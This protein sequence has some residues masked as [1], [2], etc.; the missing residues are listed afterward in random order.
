MSKRKVQGLVED[1]DKRAIVGTST[2]WKGGDLFG[3]LNRG[4]LWGEDAVGGED[5]LPRGFAMLP[6][7]GMMPPP[8]MHPL[9]HQQQL[10]QQQLSGGFPGMDGDEA[11]GEDGDGDEDGEEDFRGKK[12]SF[13]SGGGGGGGGT[14]SSNRIKGPWSPEEDQLLARLVNEFGAKK[15]SV[16]AEHVSGRIG[17]QCRERWLNHLDASVKKTP[18]SDAEDDTLMAAQNRIGNRWCEIAKLLP[19]RPENAVKNRWNSLM[20]RRRSAQGGSPPM[21]PLPISSPPPVPVSL[22]GGGGG[23]SASPFHQAAAPM[24]SSSSM[25]LAQASKAASS[26]ATSRKRNPSAKPRSHKAGSNQP[27]HMFQ[28]QQQYAQYHPSQQQQQQYFAHQQY[29]QQYQQ[30]QQ[31][32][33][34]D[35]MSPTHHHPQHHHHDGSGGVEP[36]PYSNSN[37]HPPQ[38]FPSGFQSF[39]STGPPPS[40]SAPASGYDSLSHSLLQMSMDEDPLSDLVGLG[41]P[42]LP[43]ST[44]SLSGRGRHSQFSNSGLDSSQLMRA[45]FESTSGDLLLGKLDDLMGDPFAGFLNAVPSPQNHFPTLLSPPNYLPSPSQH[46]QQ[47]HQHFQQPSRAGFFRDDHQL[48]QQ[49]PQQQPPQQ[50]LPSFQEQVLDQQQQD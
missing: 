24:A 42:K 47:Q 41:G 19:G 36:M 48:P 17:K 26:P 6:P 16:I 32:M 33:M 22:S 29:Q 44:T 4:G 12:A 30:Q 13:Q 10:H 20:N 35:L 5:Q 1:N 37:K 31:H 11:E 9:H 2:E 40:G 43:S 21:S 28:Q 14:S 38:G 27:I 49:L 45:S 50:H 39:H 18:W 46:H 25:S 7:Q 15:W 23:G 3:Q 34:H 8:P